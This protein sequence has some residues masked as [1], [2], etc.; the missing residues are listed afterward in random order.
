MSIRAKLTI[1]FVA[2]IVLVALIMGVYQAQLLDQLFKRIASRQMV[3]LAE[4]VEPLVKS[5]DVPVTDA[6]ALRRF[7]S[8]LASISESRVLLTD[9][10]GTVIADTAEGANSLVGQNVPV[11]LISKAIQGTGLD[12]FDFPMIGP[13]AV[14]VAVPWWTGERVTGVMIIVRSLKQISSTANREVVASLIRAGILASGV[15]LVVG[16]VLSRSITNP[17]KKIAGVARAISRGEFSQRIEADSADELGELASAM[18]VMSQ[19]ISRLVEGLTEEKNKLRRV[20]E[21]RQKMLSD[22][23]HDLRTPV[24]SIKGF[25]EALTDVIN[26]EDDRRRAIGIIRDEAERLSRLVEDLF[27]LVRLESG[28]LPFPMSRSDLAKVV[29]DTVARMEPVARERQVVISVD[30]PTSPVAATICEDRLVEALCNLIDNAA[31]YSPPGG[32]VQVSLS[33][34]DGNAHISVSD[35]GPGIPPEDL[36]HIFERFYRGDKSRSGRKPGAGLGLS[37][38][39]FIVEKHGGTL[40]VESRVGHGSTFTITLPLEKS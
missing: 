40:D 8:G 24:T 39:R 15:T 31:K 10:R 22:I 33:V 26:T 37:I 11:R 17:L 20:M 28:E 35:Q 23:S 6:K 27:F 4:R 2:V 12:R 25:A 30:T 14:G 21:E 7:L 29:R 16:L 32:E 18:N 34:S 5:L 19:E 36:P 38:A 3:L 9:D 1:S 13:D